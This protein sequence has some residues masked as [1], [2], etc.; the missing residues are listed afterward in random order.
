MGALLLA[1]LLRQAMERLY[2]MTN[3]R[4]NDDAT[5]GIGLFFPLIFEVPL[6]QSS[7][8]LDDT[9]GANPLGSLMQASGWKCY[10]A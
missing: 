5:D 8:I 3:G 10:M 7:R 1:A 2:G 4:G 9:N 6:I